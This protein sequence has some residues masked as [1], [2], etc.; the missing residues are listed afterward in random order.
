[1]A[2]RAPS[3]LERMTAHLAILQLSDSAFPS[4]RYTLSHGLEAFAQAGELAGPNP[5]SSLVS[6]LG[7]CVRLGV[8]PSDGVALACAHRAAGRDGSVDLDLVA[9]ADERLTAVKLA[10]E[11]RESSART[12]RALLAAASA[13]FGG[14]GV[15]QYA[16]LVRR[17][18]SP[19]NHAVV[20]GLVS[21][22]LGVPGPEAVA[23]EL[24]AFSAGWVAAAVRLALI[25]H[26]TAQAVLHRVSPVVADSAL[27]A[28]DRDVRHI[29]GCTPLVDV[30][31]MRHEAAELRLFAS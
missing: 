23:G 26:R 5:A 28:V 12:G 27:K 4:G 17:E 14:A 11:A 2:R 9:R 19:G 30:M 8:A 13:A 31:S 10:R 24:F 18:R 16:E 21:A 7:D 25:D 3:G 22:R 1:M 15:E 20:L 6:L 29:A